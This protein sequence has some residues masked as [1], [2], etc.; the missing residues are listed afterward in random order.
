MNSSNGIII[1]L[2]TVLVMVGVYLIMDKKSSPP[3]VIKE[4]V[5]EVQ[6]V[7]PPDDG[8]SVEFKLNRK[9]KL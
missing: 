4:T 5:R 8:D 3:A 7:N 2:L 1:A 9:I 6:R